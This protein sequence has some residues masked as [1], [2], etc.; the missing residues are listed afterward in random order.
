MPDALPDWLQTLRL[1]PKDAYNWFVG[2][3]MVPSFS[4]KDVWNEEHSAAFTV[5]GMLREDLLKTVHDKLGQAIQDGKDAA[6]FEEQ[7][8]PI[9]SDAGWWGK[10]E[11]TDPSTGEVAVKNLGSP[12]R[13]RLIYD[14]NL[15]NAEAAGRWQAAR[16]TQSTAGLMMRRTMDD[17]RVRKIH[18]QWNYL[19]L[20]LDDPWWNEHAA[21]CDFGCRCKDIEMDEATVQDYIDAGKPI[22]RKAPATTY[23]EFERNGERIKVPVG[24]G[25][26]FGY[27]PGDPDARQKGLD[28]LAKSKRA[29]LPPALRTEATKLAKRG[30]K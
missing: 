6:W 4:W 5:A 1:P 3:K 10:K 13:L 9:L 17:Q 2:K 21:P 20:P 26:G 30:K 27:N 22:K 11:V 29:A 25:P 24:V 16:R 19:V 14:T 18:E 28:S 8:T 7:L 23:Q 15:R 12:T